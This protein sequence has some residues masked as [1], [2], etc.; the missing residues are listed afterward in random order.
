MRLLDY[1]DLAAKGIRYSR[2]HLWRL[3]KAGRFPKPVK[4]GDG[5]RNAWVEMEIDAFI[6]AR[7]AERDQ[8][9]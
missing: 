2:C 8:A 7:I 4:L 6:K 9:A 3:I 1:D 5:A